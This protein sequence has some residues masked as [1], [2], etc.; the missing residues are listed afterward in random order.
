[1]DAKFDEK[2]KKAKRML[3]IELPLVALPIMWG[4]VSFGIFWGNVCVVA[5]FALA[6]KYHERMDALKCDECG[7]P[8]VKS[9]YYSRNGKCVGCC[10][11]K[12]S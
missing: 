8:I 2:L 6:L 10:Q 5:F 4:S 9:I 12:D 7:T 1:M 11:D 3:F